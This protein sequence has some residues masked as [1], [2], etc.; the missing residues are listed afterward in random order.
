MGAAAILRYLP[1]FCPLEEP[2]CRWPAEEGGEPAMGE[3]A[4]GGG[5]G[6]E[7]PICGPIGAS[8]A[9]PG[10]GGEM[11]GYG[12]MARGGGWLCSI[13][14]PGIKGGACCIDIGIRGPGSW[15]EKL[16]W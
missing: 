9:W 15:M 7:A 1:A 4:P 2:R 10:M 14:G 13:D 3:G 5:K 8:C 11:A 12:D 16:W 6:G